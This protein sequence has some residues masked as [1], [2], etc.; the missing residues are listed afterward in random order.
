MMGIEM[1]S[2]Q[3]FDTNELAAIEGFE[4]GDYQLGIT[5]D[6][7]L[8]MQVS[9]TWWNRMLRFL[10][11]RDLHGV[12]TDVHKICERLQSMPPNQRSERIQ[13]LFDQCQRKVKT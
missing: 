3:I 5:R 6:C 11:F 8:T 9:N 7:R 4:R 12:S 10:H 1:T 13:A 2:P